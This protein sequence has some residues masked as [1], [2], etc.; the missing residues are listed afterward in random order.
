MKYVPLVILAVATLVNGYINEN[1]DTYLS[2]V[3]FDQTLKLS[4]VRV[5]PCNIPIES[6]PITQE[7]F[8]EKYA[9]KSPVVFRRS[10]LEPERNRVFQEKCQLENLI[11]EYGEKFVT[12]S[13]ANTYSYSVSI[14]AFIFFLGLIYL[15]FFI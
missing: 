12:V 3:D 11:K 7:E 5:G 13:S 9:E 8:L 4:D 14:I 10:K 15:E 1:P 2:N 6:D